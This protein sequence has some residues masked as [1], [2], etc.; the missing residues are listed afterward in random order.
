MN[1]LE[2]DGKVCVYP[3]EFPIWLPSRSWKKFK[4]S[5]SGEQQL[6]YK[7]YDSPV[8]ALSQQTSIVVALFGKI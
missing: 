7:Y 4:R 2:I 6:K 5:I 8:Y 1:L 3:M